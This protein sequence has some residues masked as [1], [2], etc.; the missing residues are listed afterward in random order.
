MQALTFPAIESKITKQEGKYL[1]WDPIRKKK[2][3]LTPEEWV[4][5]HLV[6][7]FIQHLGYPSGLIAM[8]S[9]MKYDRMAKRSDVLVYNK[10]GGVFLLAECKAPTVKLSEQTLHQAF[11]YAKVLK[12]MHLL[13]TNG[14]THYVY[15]YNPTNAQWEPVDAFPVFVN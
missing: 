6:A 8:E 15:S 4:R 13:L 14:L 2:V 3:V 10:A 5:Q 9:G 1:I 11:T 12:P 7:Y